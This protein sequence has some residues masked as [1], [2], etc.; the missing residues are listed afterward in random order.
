MSFEVLPS[1]ESTGLETLG[2]FSILASQSFFI[3]LADVKFISLAFS[4]STCLRYVGRIHEHFTCLQASL[5]F[6]FVHASK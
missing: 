5:P 6:I 2:R 4:Y 3:F 1:A